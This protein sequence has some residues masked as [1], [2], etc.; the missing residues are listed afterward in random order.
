VRDDAPLSPPYLE[1]SPPKAPTV[2]KASWSFW[3]M[4]TVE[5]ALH[6]YVDKPRTI[7]AK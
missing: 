3:V 5:I 1:L 2:L 4:R 6:K 7:S